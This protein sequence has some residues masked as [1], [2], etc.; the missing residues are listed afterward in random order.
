MG[1]G[2]A[3]GEI[4]VLLDAAPGGLRT[5]RGEVRHWQDVARMSDAIRRGNEAAGARYRAVLM[6]VDARGETARPTTHESRARVWFAAAPDRWREEGD[7]DTLRLGDSERRWEGFASFVTERHPAGVDQAPMLARLLLPAGLLGAQRFGDVAETEMLGR[8]CLTATGTR[9][10]PGSSPMLGLS[11]GVHGIRFGLA[12]QRIA[13]DAEH[14]FLLRHESLLD[15]EPIE[16]TEF[17]D[18]AVDVPLPDDTFRLPPGI[19][20]QTE[21]EELARMLREAGV[22]PGSVDLTDSSAVT[23]ATFQAYGMPV[24]RPS[25]DDQVAQ[26]VPWGPPPP[27]PAAAEAE[28]TAAFHDHGAAD[29]SGTDLVNVQAGAGLAGPLAAASRRLPGAT[30]ENSHFVVRAVR[31]VCPD[32]A[33]VWFDVEVGGRVPSPV[34]AGRRGRAVRTGGRWVIERGT[35]A[36]VLALGGARVPPPPVAE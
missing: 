22:D 33:V 34:V 35:M 7:G 16:V 15:G 24:G 25:L 2:A 23:T 8:R 9:R 31:F 27:D 11:T 29:P 14:G 18:L 3:R 1:A 19:S 32:E 5:L 26:F 21:A 28:I 13:V 17:T 10:A 20:V 36:E 6:A 30:A 4:V 12:D